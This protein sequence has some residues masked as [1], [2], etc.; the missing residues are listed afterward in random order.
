MTLIDKGAALFLVSCRE[1]WKS[2]LSHDI[3]LISV[4]RVV[5]TISIPFTRKILMA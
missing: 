2:L 3:S 5:V 1:V 4:Q